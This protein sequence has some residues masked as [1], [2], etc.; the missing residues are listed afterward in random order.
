MILINL[1]RVDGGVYGGFDGCESSEFGCTNETNPLGL[2]LGFIVLC[3]LYVVFTSINDSLTE[4]S[5]KRNIRKRE[6]QKFAMDEWDRK[7]MA[8][9]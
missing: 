4:K 5:I 8:N 2:I 1:I 7:W 6:K 3:I 9:S